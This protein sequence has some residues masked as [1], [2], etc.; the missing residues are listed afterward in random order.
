MM[1]DKDAGIKVCPLADDGRIADHFCRRL[2]R[3]EVTNYLQISLEGLFDHQHSLAW[4]DFHGFVN[5]DVRCRAAETRVVIFGMIDKNK[6]AFLH[7][8]DLVYTGGL[9]I[10]ITNY[11][12]AQEFSQPLNGYGRRKLHS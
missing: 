7:L 9:A 5:N 11:P 6:I 10:F 2:E 12:G 1:A 8:V 4:W 3:P